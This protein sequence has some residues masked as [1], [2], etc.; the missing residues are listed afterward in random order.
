MC[1]NMEVSQ[2]MNIPCTINNQGSI[3]Y[4]LFVIADSE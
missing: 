4:V 3:Q 2:D 1:E